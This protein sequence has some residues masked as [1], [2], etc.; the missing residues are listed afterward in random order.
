MHA[1]ADEKSKPSVALATAQAQLRS[2]HGRLKVAEQ[3][4][5]EFEKTREAQEA[6]T[7]TAHE[8]EDATEK[9]VEQM[10]TTHRQQERQIALHGVIEADAR[11]NCNK[12]KKALR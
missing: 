5:S 12:L 7:K 3:K 6:A 11:A 1:L 4:I 10:Q 2:S 8:R 9:Q